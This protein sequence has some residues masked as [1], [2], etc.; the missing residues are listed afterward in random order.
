MATSSPF[1][2]RIGL[3]DADIAGEMFSGMLAGTRSRVTEDR[4]PASLI[5]TA[6]TIPVGR[7]T[8]WVITLAQQACVSA[9]GFL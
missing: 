8:S 5:S 7:M 2:E 1:G 9:G 3:H 6:A 4:Q